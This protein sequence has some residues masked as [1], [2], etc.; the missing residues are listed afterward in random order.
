MLA[1]F[2]AK[3]MQRIDDAEIK[4]KVAGSFFGGEEKK[5]ESMNIA[6]TIT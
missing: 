1:L 3:I 2:D 6:D 4:T 5:L